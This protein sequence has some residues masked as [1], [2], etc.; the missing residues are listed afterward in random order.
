MST[1]RRLARSRKGSAGS[2]L[3]AS[4]V[5]KILLDRLMRE[6]FPKTCGSGIEDARPEPMT[7]LRPDARRRPE[8]PDKKKTGASKRPLR[9]CV[10]FDEDASARSAEILISHVA[11]DCRCDTQ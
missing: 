6:S 5:C 2:C 1:F 11:S 8:N 9:I 3:D 4:F 10:V 7:H